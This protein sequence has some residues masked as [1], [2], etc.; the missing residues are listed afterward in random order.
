MNTQEAQQTDLEAWVSLRHA[1]WP[2]HD[3]DSLTEGAR[4]LLS[5]TDEVCFLLIHPSQGAV[6]FVEAA[7][8]SSPEGPYCHVEGWYVAP[9]F[10][11]QGYG[12]DLIGCVELW[13]LHRSICLLTSDT[14][15]DYPLSPA[16]HARAGFKKIHELMIFAKRLQPEAGGDS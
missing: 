4:V 3:V 11:G 7:V 1:L 6:G 10:R 5:S 2:K 9:E 13:S 8:H 15:A 16:A 14:E 12:K